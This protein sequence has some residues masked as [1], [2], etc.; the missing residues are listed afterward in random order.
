[1]YIYMYI[2]IYVYIIY[3]YIYIYIYIHLY[4][5]IDYLFNSRNGLL[6]YSKADAE[7]RYAWDYHLYK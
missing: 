6:E 7:S 5:H 1:M 2:Y 4:I 3:I